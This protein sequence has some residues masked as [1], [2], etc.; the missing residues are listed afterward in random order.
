MVVYVLN[1][2]LIIDV[3]LLRRK[4]SVDETSCDY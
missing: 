3:Y 4:R 1:K 2:Q